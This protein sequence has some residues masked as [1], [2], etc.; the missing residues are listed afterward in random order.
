M[1]DKTGKGPSRS[2]TPLGPAWRFDVNT[3]GNRRK[4]LCPYC[5]KDLSGLLT[6]RDFNRDHVL[7]KQFF[8]LPIPNDLANIIVR[9]CMAC[10]SSF[11]KDEE[12]VLALFSAH[13][14]EQGT[15]RQI[16]EQVRK[17]LPKNPGLK[18]AVGRGIGSIE[19]HSPAGL[20]LGTHKTF[21]VDEKR[22]HAV[23][24]KWVRGFHFISYDQVLPSTTPIEVLTFDPPH[25]LNDHWD[26]ATH[27]ASWPNKFEYWCSRNPADPA[28]TRWSFIL[29]GAIG[30]FARANHTI[31]RHVPDVIKG[32]HGEFYTPV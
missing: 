10:N 30:F 5:G 21:D 12:Y 25:S 16:S 15:G 1:G 9:S 14:G 18:H 8:P 7:A 17:G 4:R 24:G 26:E 11:K 22:V 31:G 32:L 13:L 2:V 6:G 28:Q 23:V 20:Y 27:G 29:W 3:H 19:L